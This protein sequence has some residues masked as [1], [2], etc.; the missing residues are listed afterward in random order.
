MMSSPKM[1]CAQP[2]GNYIMDGNRLMNYE[3]F[4]PILLAKSAAAALTDLR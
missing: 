3:F 4:W 1:H 2:A